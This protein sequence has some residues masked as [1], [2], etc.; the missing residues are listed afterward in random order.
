MG[1]ISF[2]MLMGFSVESPSR[3]GRR[4]RRAL[5]MVAAASRYWSS[6]C[7]A[8]ASAPCAAAKDLFG[9]GPAGRGGVVQAV[10]ST[11]MAISLS[12][13][14]AQKGSAADRHALLSGN[15]VVSMRPETAARTK[16]APE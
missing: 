10:L 9:A 13:N 12:S 14:G 2:Q 15:R 1:E 4:H 7:P 5:T 8:G 3:R 11:W 6:A 16:G